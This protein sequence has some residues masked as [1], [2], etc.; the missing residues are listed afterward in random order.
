[1]QLNFVLNQTYLDFSGFLEPSGLL[2]SEGVVLFQQVIY[3]FYKNFG[4]EFSWRFTNDPYE[5][6]VSEIMLQQTQ[7]DR[8]REKYEQFIQIFPDF[9]RLAAASVAQVIS[10]WQGLGYNRRALSLQIC[11][12]KIIND[13]NGILPDDPELLVKFKGIGKATAA[14]I[15]AF[16]FNKPTVFI[17][18]NIR[19]VYIYSFFKNEQGI[20]DVQ[21]MPL[22]EQT[23][24]QAN[25]RMWYYALMDYGVAL[26][27]L[28]GNPSRK[29]KHYTRQS[30]FEGSDRQIRGKIIKLL[31]DKQKPLSL[32]EF[33]KVVTGEENRINCALEQLINEG[34]IIKKDNV[35]LLAS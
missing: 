30:R 1:M 15:C 31:V 19:A 3:E 7:T 27:K 12:Q 25:S 17:E 24:D 33:Y 32:V 11:A 16:A 29:S 34:F 26:K 22:I 5:V 23:L 28:F 13:Y 8:V 21:L 14:S 35:F 10:Q 6:V 20:S 9:E 4:R 18:T 2:S